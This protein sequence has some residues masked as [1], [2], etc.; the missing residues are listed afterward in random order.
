[1]K[2]CLFDISNMK[3]NLYNIEQQNLFGNQV[4]DQT[5]ELI[6]VRQKKQI[7]LTQKNCTESY[8][9]HMLAISSHL[10]LLSSGLMVCIKSM[11]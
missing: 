3:Q 11:S 1:M 10:Y 5:L 2:K 6:L 4:K 9:K 7:I 8:I